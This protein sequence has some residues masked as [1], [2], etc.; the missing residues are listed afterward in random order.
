MTN[1]YF[2]AGILT[3]AI[4]VTAVSVSAK[5]SR[6]MHG[7]QP[8]FSELDADHNGEIT[9]EEITAHGRARL[10]TADTD[11]DGYLT[12]EELSAMSRENGEK[13]INRMMA[14]LDTNGDGKLSTDEMPRGLPGQMFEEADAD[15][16]GGLNE[17]EFA[18]LRRHEKPRQP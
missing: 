2:I 15:G 16:S 14:R 1:K 5:E 11:G 13:R 12:R 4:A 6:R 8:S 9:Q 18:S 17:E 10:G 7:H 3:T